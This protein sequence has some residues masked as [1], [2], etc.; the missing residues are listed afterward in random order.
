[1]VPVWSLFLLAA[2]ITGWSGR[3]NGVQI[4]QGTP[5][6]HVEGEKPSLSE[7]ARS[8]RLSVFLDLLNT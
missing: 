8:V 2:V 1:M 3:V 4:Q 6:G 7:D 5:H